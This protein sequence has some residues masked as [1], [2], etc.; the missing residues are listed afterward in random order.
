MALSCMFSPEVQNTRYVLP[1]LGG[2][3]FTRDNST[4]LTA[5][6]AWINS[7]TC[8]ESFTLQFPRASPYRKATP[9]TQQILR[10]YWINT[11]SEE[12]RGLGKLW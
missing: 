6:P 4:I 9:K 7:G 3:K 12:E 10:P 1:G 2:E 11:S 5:H 8:V